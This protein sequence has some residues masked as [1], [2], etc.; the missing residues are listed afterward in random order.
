[1]T[2]W[3]LATEMCRARWA[4]GRA[5]MTTEASRTIIS[6]AT[7]MTIRAQYRRG[8]GW[9]TCCGSPG[10]ASSVVVMGD[11]FVGRCLSLL[12]WSP[13]VRALAFLDGTDTLG[14]VVPVIRIL[15]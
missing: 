7:A 8:S 11:S 12:S 15:Y 9:S 10:R 3:R 6:W 1:M 14:A 2:H 13:G 4:E 5:T